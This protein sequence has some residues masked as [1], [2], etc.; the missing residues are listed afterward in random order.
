MG[1]ALVSG[2]DGKYKVTVYRF[3]TLNL[4]QIDYLRFTNCYEKTNK[5]CM[6]WHDEIWLVSIVWQRGRRKHLLSVSGNIWKNKAEFYN[7]TTCL[8]KRGCF[9]RDISVVTPLL[10]LHEYIKSKSRSK[11]FLSIFTNYR[12]FKSVVWYTKITIYLLPLF[13]FT[14]LF[15]FLWFFFKPSDN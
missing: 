8:L 13:D 9:N 11:C 12:L 6:L 10:Y 2:F 14:L 15:I 4:T 7:K 1:D 5:K 3:Q